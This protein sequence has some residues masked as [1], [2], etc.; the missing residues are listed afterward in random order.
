MAIVK[1]KNVRLSFPDLFE[2]VQFEN[3]GPFAYKAQLLMEPKGTNFDACMAAINEVANEKWKTKAGIMLKEIMP[4][5]KA[6]CFIDGNRRTYDGYADKWAL[7][8]SR[9]QDK[10]RPTIIDADKSPLTAADGK[11]YAGCY[12]NANVEFW[13]QDNQYGKA[14]RATLLGIQFYKDG[15][16]FSAGAAASDVDDFESMDENAG[17]EA[18]VI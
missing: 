8:T 14:I 1:L 3:K 15:E 9:S 7:S 17:D 16:A 4:D 2:A 5:K 10:G 18:D 12:V 11:P 13:A 6:C